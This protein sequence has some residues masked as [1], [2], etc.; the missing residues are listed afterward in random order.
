MPDEPN[1]PIMVRANITR[2]E[3]AD[4][5]RRRV[6]AGMTGAEYLAKLIRDGLR[7]EDG[8]SRKVREA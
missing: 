8:H 3:W 6:L 7:A 2:E 5:Q 1:S 4:I